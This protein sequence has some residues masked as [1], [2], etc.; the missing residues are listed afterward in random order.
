MRSVSH[1]RTVP[2]VALEQLAHDVQRR[3][4]VAME[5]P[6]LAREQRFRVRMRHHRIGQC[7]HLRASGQRHQ[8]G[9]C[10]SENKSN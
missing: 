10:R 7:A 9:H 6:V 4:L 1:C 2:L 5:I 3:L 8:H